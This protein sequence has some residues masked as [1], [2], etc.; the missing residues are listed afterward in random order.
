VSPTELVCQ[1]FDDS[2][3]DELL[4]GG[5]VFSTRADDT[6]RR[7]NVLASNLNLEQRPDDLLRDGRWLE[8][9]RLAESA[10]AAVETALAN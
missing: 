8:F 2:G 1:L 6:L 3:L 9:T 5:I 10:L 4:E 7:M